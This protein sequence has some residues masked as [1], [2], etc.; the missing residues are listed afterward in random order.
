MVIS[1]RGDMDE[2]NFRNYL[3]RQ[4]DEKQ[5]HAARAGAYKA[6][7]L[8]EI[9]ENDKAWRALHIF[10]R[11]PTELA[12]EPLRL[13][14]PSGPRRARPLP[15]ARR[16][17]YR[18]HV[19]ATVR[20]A[21]TMALAAATTGERDDTDPPSSNSSMPGQL[22]AL[23]GGGCCTR[24]LEHAYLIP[25][26]L[27]R[28]MDTHPQLTEEQVVDAYLDRLSATTQSDSCINHT[29]TGCSLP[30]EM[31][32][33]TCNRY[34]CASLAKLQVAHGGVAGTVHPVLV[35]RRKQDQWHRDD[36]GPDN[37]INATALLTE[38]GVR[39]MLRG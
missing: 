29:K 23:C 15:Q 39:H 12:A 27:R 14:L 2:T 18:A 22:C 21:A 37:A 13:L 25:A 32:S 1:R 30:R 19:T 3:R 26:T 31:R 8:A 33:D 4:A 34:A 16:D 24:G 10:A 20:A 38:N 6:R 17:R 9:E 5:L 35:V 11:L 36:A 28:F 7:H